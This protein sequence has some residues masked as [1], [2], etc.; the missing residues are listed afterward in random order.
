LSERRARL[1][2][3][4]QLSEPLLDR[5]QRVH[6]RG[7]ERLF[8]RQDGVVLRVG[9]RLFGCVSVF[10]HVSPFAHVP[11]LEQARPGVVVSSCRRRRALRHSERRK[12]A[13][14]GG[15]APSVVPGLI[16]ALHLKK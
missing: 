12:N 5:Q 10:T 4:Q 16:L 15:E 2:V 7:R 6:R 11:M 9:E 14:F 8:G 1:Q 13:P 3:G